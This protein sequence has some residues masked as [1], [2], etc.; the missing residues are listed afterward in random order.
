MSQS[1]LSRAELYALVKQTLADVSRTHRCHEK[2]REILSA[3]AKRI[4]AA[5]TVLLALS[6]TGILTTLITDNSA[7]TWAA[8]FTTFASLLFSVWQLQFAPESEV[9]AHKE[10]ADKY[11]SLRSEFRT[12]RARMKTLMDDELESKYESLMRQLN[13]LTA[14]SPRTSRRAYRLTREKD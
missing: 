1:I 7:A 13:E 11:Y 10:A 14:A 2:D 5:N 4:R 6:S 9:A 12:L 8:A 3:R